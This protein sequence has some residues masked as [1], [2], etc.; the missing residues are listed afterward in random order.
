MSPSKL[1]IRQL[2]SSVSFFYK[3]VFSLNVGK[4]VVGTRAILKKVEGIQHKT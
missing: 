3:T 1:R 2:C 4:D